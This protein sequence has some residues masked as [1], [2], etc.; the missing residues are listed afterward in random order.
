MG[1]PMFFLARARWLVVLSGL[2]LAFPLVAAEPA[3]EAPSDSAA[4]KAT[5]VSRLARS[6]NPALP[7]AVGKAVVRQE[8]L[9]RAR[10]L[11]ASRGEAAGLDAG[12][13]P[14][15]PEWRQ[16]EAALVERAAQLINERIESPQWFY[17]VLEREISRILDG[18]EADYIATHFTT[19]AGNEQRI[20]LEMRL[21][22]EVLMANYTFT[23]RID[24]NIPGLENDLQE[25]SEAYWALEP[26]RKRDFMN[27]PQAIKFAGQSAGLKFTRMLAIRGI[28]GFIGH[29]DDVAAQAR[30]S[31]EQSAGLISGYIEAYRARVNDV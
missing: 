7:V 2:V 17:A 11:L 27:D 19:T 31:V 28:E 15:A 12:W 3:N 1:I 4:L 25:L 8:A 22:G 23:N 10:E 13:N 9:L 18:E 26:F 6:L 16:A 21:I 5:A 20:L 30:T 14:G 29:I 24:Y